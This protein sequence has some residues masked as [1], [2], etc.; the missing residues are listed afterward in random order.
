MSLLPA[1]TAPYLP[2]GLWHP[3]QCL[4]P[5]LVALCYSG[6]A[7]KGSGDSRSPAVE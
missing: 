5:N 1:P 7:G 6:R 3:V 2:R 4:T